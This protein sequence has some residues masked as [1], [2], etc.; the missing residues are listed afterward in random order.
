M[1]RS[2]FG[3]QLTREHTCSKPYLWFAKAGQQWRCGRAM[4]SGDRC[5]KLWEVIVDPDHGN[6]KKL[7]WREVGE[8]EP[9]GR[10]ERF[11]RVDDPELMYWVVDTLANQASVDPKRVE[12]G[13]E[14]FPVRQ[15][16]EAVR[17]HFEI[18][19]VQ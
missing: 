6:P 9:S 11:L 1:T 12:K 18:G 8:P 16:L 10:L 14:L 4:P 13:A 5:G 3:W 17:S 19:K 7:A 2:E 15:V